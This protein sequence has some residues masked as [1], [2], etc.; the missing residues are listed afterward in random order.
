[1]KIM[2]AAVALAIIA[3]ASACTSTGDVSIKHTTLTEVNQNIHDGLT[4][5][6]QVYQIYGEPGQKG[7]E[8]GYEFWVYSFTAGREDGLSIAQDVVGLGML[9]EKSNNKSKTLTIVFNNGIVLSHS[10]STS[11][12][13]SS[14]GIRQ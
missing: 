8:N 1:M 11:N 7:Y 2:R 6:S 13:S 4:T 9:G 3:S 5:V 12:F 14:S 10:F